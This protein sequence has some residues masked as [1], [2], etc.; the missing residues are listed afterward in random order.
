MNKRLIVV[1]RV[2]KNKTG[3]VYQISENKK[4]GSYQSGNR[5]ISILTHDASKMD[6]GE[7]E[8]TV[9]VTDKNATHSFMKTKRL[10]LTTE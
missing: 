2:N 1:I 10:F 9:L 5:Y 4:P 3:E 8:L 7:Y 6:Q